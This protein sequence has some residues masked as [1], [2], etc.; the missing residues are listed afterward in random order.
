MER[1]DWLDGSGGCG[2]WWLVASEGESVEY[3]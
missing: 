3:L 2:G 1:C